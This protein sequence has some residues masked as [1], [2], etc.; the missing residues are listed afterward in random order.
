M[1]QFG[2]KCMVSSCQPQSSHL[3]NGNVTAPMQKALEWR[4][5]SPGGR[6]GGLHQNAEH[7]VWHA[8]RRKRETRPPPILALIGR[9][10]WAHSL[11]SPKASN[12]SAGCP[13]WGSPTAT[14]LPHGW[15]GG[16]ICWLPAGGLMAHFTVPAPPGAP[17]TPA[18]FHLLL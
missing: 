6:E 18:F 7:H 10:H 4:S 14:P 11:R 1:Y 17:G 2:C 9:I 16:I 8:E 12:G 15:V 5:C 3:Q 13:A